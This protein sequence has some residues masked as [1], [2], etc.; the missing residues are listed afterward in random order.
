MSDR[1]KK[2]YV[3]IYFR[4]PASLKSVQVSI[5]CHHTSSNTTELEVTTCCSGFSLR[6]SWLDFMKPS[7][8]RLY[9]RI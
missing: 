2:A 6:I 3:G 4:E 9:I 1:L 5:A 7:L 8:A